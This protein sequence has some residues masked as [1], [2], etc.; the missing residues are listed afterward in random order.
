MDK[1]TYATNISVSIEKQIMIIEWA[2]G[3]KSVYPLDGLRKACPCVEC[4]GGHANMA[5]KATA[6]VFKSPHTETRT[7]IKLQEVGNYAM[8]IFWGDGHDTGIYRWEYLRDIC[9]VEN[10]II[11]LD[12]YNL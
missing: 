7:I 8:Q 10:N 12:D 5:I 4:A 3:H 2:D 11:S 9:P 6:E 1:R